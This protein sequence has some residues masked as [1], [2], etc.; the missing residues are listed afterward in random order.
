MNPAKFSTPIQTLS[1]ESNQV[2]YLVMFGGRNLRI[3]FLVSVRKH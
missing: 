3:F 2:A 1:I